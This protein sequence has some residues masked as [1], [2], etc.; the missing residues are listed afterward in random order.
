MRLRVYFYFMTVRIKF[1]NNYLPSTLLI[2]S[3]SNRG[4]LLET[5]IFGSIIHILGRRLDW[6][7]SK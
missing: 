5:E 2:V 4:C 7:F 6:N 3:D 1:E